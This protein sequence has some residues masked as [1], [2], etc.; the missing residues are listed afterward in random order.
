MTLAQ[1]IERDL[2]RLLAQRQAL[3]FKLSLS[4]IAKHFKVSPM[5]VRMAVQSMVDAGM[6]TKG[7]G[8]RLK[9]IESKL[10]DPQVLAAESSDAQV[11]SIHN[12][13]VAE[14]VRRSLTRDEHYLRESATAQQYGVG[15]TIVRRVFS[16][17]AGRG[18]L[19]HVPRCGWQIRPY[20]EQDTIDYLV[21]REMMERQ[22]LALAFDKL[23]LKV[24]R[25]MREHNHP[26]QPN[27]PA[28]LDNRM[29]EYW[30]DL[31]GNRYI[32]DFFKRDGDYYAIIFN[33]A[34]LE[35]QAIDHMIQ[36]H[37]AILDALLDRDLPR[38]LA[39]L[40]SHILS[41]RA[42]VAGLIRRLKT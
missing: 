10:P 11:Q 12:Q 25:L 40:S 29:H 1:R 18:L 33:Q 2:T 17:L 19:I 30:I 20:R 34:G 5:P 23:D 32:Q 14:I 8:G 4:E 31:C 16:E 36:Q 7:K 22:A 28:E 15:R 26:G 37:H 13:L 9:V 39:A 41:Q 27:N 35:P 6:L 42:N 38:A 24:L 3:P 21:V